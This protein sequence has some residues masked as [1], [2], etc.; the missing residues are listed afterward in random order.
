MD[1]PRRKSVSADTVS[2]EQIKNFQPP[3]YEKSQQA[4]DYLFEVVKGND[5]LQVLFG[6]LQ[7]EQVRKVIDAMFPRDVAKGENLIVQGDEGDNFYIVAEGHFDIF[8]ER[9][10]GSSSKVMECGPGACFGE[11][12]LMYF[13][14]R[15][16]TVTATQACKVWGLDRESFRLM[17][18][19]AENTKVRTYENFLEAVEILQDLTKYERL[20]LSDMLQSDLWDTGEDIITQGEDGDTFYIL[21]DGEAKAYITGE[22]GQLEVKHYSR[23]GDYFGEI[24]L[25]SPGPRKATVRAV[26]TGC[27]TLSVCREDFNNVLGPIKDILIKSIDKYPQYA[28]FL[29]EE[30]ARQAEERAEQEKLSKMQD[31]SRRAGVSADSVSEEQMKNWKPPVHEKSAEAKQRLIKNIQDGKQAQVLFGHLSSDHLETVVL[32]MFPKQVASGEVLIQQGEEGD[33]FYIV[34]EGSFD[35]FVQRGDEASPGGKVLEYGPGAS[36]GELALMYNCKRAATV[37]A[38]SNAKVWA[39]DRQSFRMMLCTAENTRAR[40]YEGFL[41]NVDIFKHLTKFE[42]A[43]V[44]DLLTSELFEGGEEIVKQGDMGNCFYILEDG[45]AKAYISGDKGEIEVKSYNNPGDYFGEIALITQGVRRA[46][47]RAV[48]DGCSVLSVE[49]ADFDKVLGP[50]KDRLAKNIDKYPQY[51]DAIKE[52]SWIT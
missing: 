32:A 43:Q 12:A 13:A 11:L 17:L 7:E 48:N 51:A 29:R 39:L 27:T 34:E 28:D 52:A 45:Q 24:A 18:C 5:K 35:V 26:G 37:R 50:I 2:E 23:P 1:R 38:T 21:E 10:D 46:T 40:Q 41:E 16:A 15:A 22:K 42:L 4:K 25:L 9:S 44:S 30:E 14:P 33:N 8:V 20:K 36:F 31:R 49:R 47:V 6:H 3:V 19:T